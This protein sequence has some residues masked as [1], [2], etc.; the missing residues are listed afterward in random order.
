MNQREGY[1]GI[2]SLKS[3]R[4]FGKRSII[5]AKSS[6]STLRE[7]LYFNSR[8]KSIPKSSL[9]NPVI[10]DIL[11]DEER[12]LRNPSLYESIIKLR[13]MDL[14]S[15]RTPKKIGLK[16]NVR[17]PYVYNDYHMRNTNPGYSRNTAGAFFFR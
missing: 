6:T 2:H 4:S 15:E 17:I 3:T 9:K 14:L 16:A 7:S 12:I 13:D 11:N 5:S 1:S 8:T 10:E